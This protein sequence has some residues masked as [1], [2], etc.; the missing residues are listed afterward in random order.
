MIIIKWGHAASRKKTDHFAN[1]N[2]VVKTRYILSI[3]A[4]VRQEVINLFSYIKKVA[5]SCSNIIRADVIESNVVK[6]QDLSSFNK[7]AINVLSRIDR[8]VIS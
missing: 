7:K 4:I 1:H 3:P 6:T 8:E 5:T 2:G